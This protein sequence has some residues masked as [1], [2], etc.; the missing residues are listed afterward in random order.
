V[1]FSIPFL[2]ERGFMFAGGAPM[3]GF[4]AYFFRSQIIRAALGSLAI[5]LL[6][7]A[8]GC[9]GPAGSGN[10]A[11]DEPVPDGIVKLKEA[12]KDRATA[13]KA[14]RGAPRAR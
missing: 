9:G 13:K 2:I 1:R 8:G 4:V 5:G 7:L 3:K 12:M 6:C 14:P 11:E 10:Q